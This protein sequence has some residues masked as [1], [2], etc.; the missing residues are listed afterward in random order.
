METASIAPIECQPFIESFSL[1]GLFEIPNIY[2][3]DAGCENGCNVEAGLCNLIEGAAV[4]TGAA[5]P[6]CTGA[7]PPGLICGGSGC[8]C[9]EPEKFCSKGETYLNGTCGIDDCAFQYGDEWYCNTGTCSCEKP[10][11]CGEDADAGVCSL[12]CK[13]P[14]QDCS[15]PEALNGECLCM[16]EGGELVVIA[17]G[18]Q[19]MYSEILGLI[20]G[21][22]IRN[23]KVNEDGS[24]VLGLREGFAYENSELVETK[25]AKEGDYVTF[26]DPEGNSATVQ[27]VKIDTATGI[28]YIYVFACPNG[29]VY[30]EEQCM[31]VGGGIIQ[32]PEGGISTGNEFVP[33]Y[34]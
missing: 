31:C 30:D 26:S 21:Y 1:F 27:I 17:E 10:T 5:V 6:F 2:I 20:G 24:V 4:P 15:K 33:W 22:Q 23:E 29:Q 19:Y 9:I 8:D 18:K 7:C 16:C 11:Y 28:I 3:G 32:P 25:T 12:E 34:E 14:A 13:T